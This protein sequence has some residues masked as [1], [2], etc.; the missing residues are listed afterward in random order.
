MTVIVQHQFRACGIHAQRSHSLPPSL[1]RGLRIT[2]GRDRKVAKE[3]I[4]SPREKAEGDVHSRSVH[5][6]A[7]AEDGRLG[8][9]RVGRHKP[10]MPAY[11]GTVDHLAQLRIRPAVIGCDDRFKLRWRSN[12]QRFRQNRKAKC[13]QKTRSAET[14]KNRGNGRG[15]KFVG[16]VVCD[17]RKFGE[18][19][20]QRRVKQ[21]LRDR[22]LHFPSFPCDAV[23]AL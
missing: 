16:S 18:N 4:R 8:L 20:G 21:S 23:Y 9:I 14:A 13:N 5:R 19:A 6:L 12:A 7:R 17:A 10:A 2:R 15:G 1:E 22:V 11:I 3:T